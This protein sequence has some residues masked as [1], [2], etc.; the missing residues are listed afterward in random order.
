MKFSD[1]TDKN[2]LVEEIDFLCDT[3]ST[4]YPIEDKTRNINEELYQAG[5]LMWKHSPLWNFDDANQTTHA[6]STTTL[7]DNQADY[8]LPSTLIHLQRVSILDASGLEYDLI[9]K[10]Y[11]D[12]PNPNEFMKTPGRPIYFAKRGNSIWL[13]PKVKAA[14]VTLAAGLKVY[15]TRLA[16]PFVKTDTTK[17][18]GFN[19]GYHRLLSLGAS[20][21]FCL[22]NNP[23]RYARLKLEHRE[24]EQSFI[25]W[26]KE[27]QR[28]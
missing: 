26:I 10:N 28:G 25:N 8:S 3:N 11:D 14:D 21:K 27:R 22:V 23:D 5:I 15:L 16:D 17:V 24:L 19:A 2:G 1:P 12:L 4:S 13:F 7:V 18:P 6:I 20:E 9:E